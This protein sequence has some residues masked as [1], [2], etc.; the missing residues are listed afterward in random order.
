[1]W[2]KPDEKMLVEKFG[3]NAKIA[4]VLFI[5]LGLIGIFFPIFT[6][7][8]T[9]IVISWLMLF[10]GFMA[11]Y[12]TYI[13]DKS[14]WAGWLKA[15]ILMGVAMYMIFSPFNAVATIGLLFSIYFFM[16]SFSGFMMASNSYL[17]KGWGLW[18]VNAVMSM[19]MAIIFLVGWPFTS[20]YLIGLLV[21]FSLFFDGLALVMGAN[22]FKDLLDE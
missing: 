21:G 3:K 19:L 17:N 16:D 11:M 6:S 18:A 10:A 22:F 15:V 20:L 13:T 9:V 12:F 8:T 7:Y 1:M 14:D 5:I 2:K 4:G